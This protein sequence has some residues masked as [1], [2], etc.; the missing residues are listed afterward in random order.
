MLK[1][2]NSS[3]K[4][5]KKHGKSLI[6]LKKTKKL[7]KNVVIDDEISV[8]NSNDMIE[9]F[10]CRPTYNKEIER[11][12]HVKNKSITQFEITFNYTNSNTDENIPD[13]NEYYGGFCYNM[14]VKR[15]VKKAKINIMDKSGLD[16]NKVY[17]GFKS[18]FTPDIRNFNNKL[19]NLLNPEIKLT[20]K[21]DKI[22][23]LYEAI[24]FARLLINL[25]PNIKT[26]N[27]IVKLIREFNDKIIGNFIKK[28]KFELKIDTIPLSKL[29]KLNNGNN[30]LSA[31][32]NNPDNSGLLII[33]YNS[34]KKNKNKNKPI[35]FVGKGVL[36]DSGGYNL[37]SSKNMTDMKTDMAGMAICIGVILGIANMNIEIPIDIK[38]I[39]P[40][41]TNLIGENTILPSSV[42]TSLSGKKIEVVDTDAEGRLIIGEAINYCYDRWSNTKGETEFDTII[43]IATLTGQQDDLG[44]KMFANALYNKQGKVL[45]NRLMGASMANNEPIYE[46]PLMEEYSY[47]L[48]SDIADYKNIS[49]KWQSDII[50][51]GLFIYKML[52]NT[53]KTHKNIKW[54]HI[55]IAGVANNINDIKM[56]YPKGGSGFGIRTIIDFL[57]RF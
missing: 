42:Y 10:L 56:Y 47:L 38:I 15:G 23:K 21:I 35:I 30:L 29:N 33:E 12:F 54:I 19:E 44:S 1:I 43:D 31:F 26:F 32:N 51:G 14:T 40:I 17:H 8:N 28:N 55:D 7:I 22:D 48:E 27:L 25:P 45:Y 46:L 57:G 39:C 20:N 41:I 24:Y 6:K 16:Y 34:K 36:F 9:Y 3:K 53:I 37:K 4:A 50:V 49:D 18:M 2:Y 5:Y 11:G 13:I 52:P